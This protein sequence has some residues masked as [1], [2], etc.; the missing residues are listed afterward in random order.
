MR[1]PGEAVGGPASRSI[2]CP[3]CGQAVRPPDRT[4]AEWSC[5]AC[6]PVEP[7]T[8]AST[9][10]PAVVDELR[11]RLLAAELRERLVAAELRERLL[12][13]D[14][15]VPLWCTW[16]LPTGW[17][18]TGLS[19]AGDDRRPPTATALAVSGPAPFSTGPADI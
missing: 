5:S 10:R 8:V 14:D 19:W 12:A 4:T 11:E 2:C 16:P 13:A 6:G 15:R 7:L 17:T 3:R 18:V 9:G 1:R